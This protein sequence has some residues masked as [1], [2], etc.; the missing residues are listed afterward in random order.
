[1]IELMRSTHK[2][3]KR[4]IPAILTPEVLAK[5]EHNKPPRR[6]GRMNYYRAEAKRLGVTVVAIYK[7]KERLLK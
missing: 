6:K 1:M 7:A 5:I 4:G 3:K 2:F